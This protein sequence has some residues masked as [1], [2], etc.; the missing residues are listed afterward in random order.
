MR[1]QRHQVDIATL[2]QK[3][4]AQIN[5]DAEFEVAAER[6][7]PKPGMKM[8]FSENVGEPLSRFTNLLLVSVG[9]FLESPRKV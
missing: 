5:P 1:S 7:Q 2:D 6:T 4:H 8:R 9:Q 3:Q